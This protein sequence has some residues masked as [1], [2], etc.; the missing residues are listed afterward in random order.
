ME[1]SL[2]GLIR[3]RK[4]VS[5]VL[6]VS[7]TGC[8]WK[9]TPPPGKALPATSGP[10]AEAVVLDVNDGGVVWGKGELGEAVKAS[11]LEKRAFGRVYYP[12]VPRNPPSYKLIIQAGG[13][14]EEEVGLGI[15]KSIIVGAL[16]FLPVGVIRFN[17]Y[18]VLDA[19]VT[20]SADGK[21]VRHF[22]TRARTEV[23]HTMFS[24]TD[25]YEP[26]GRK[27]AFS[28]LADEIVR[29]LAETK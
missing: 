19:Q 13:N 22:S 4:L 6:I 14:I 12:I 26:A 9:V 27:A 3:S 20:Y 8:G 29:V 28:H 5:S 10:I 1:Q 24:D 15:A 18:F 25:E 16:F 17:R 2:R 23:S 11:L 21:D 7:L